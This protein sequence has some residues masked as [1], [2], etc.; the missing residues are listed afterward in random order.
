[1]TI[2]L[3][4]E[5]IKDFH[6]CPHFYEHKH[7]NHEEEPN[8]ARELQAQRFEEILKRVVS[9]F[10]YKR[11]GA[12]TPSYNAL[13]NRW[14]KLWF[15]KNMTAYDLSIERHESAHGNLA[16][17]SN[18]AAAALL[19]FHE[20]FANRAGDPILI[21]E[22]FLIPLSKEVRLQGNFDLILRNKD[23]YQIIKWSSKVRRPGITTFNFDFAALRL[24][25]EYKNRVPANKISYIL[26]DLGST[27]PGAT[28]IYPTQDDLNALL[29]WVDQIKNTQTFIPRRGYTVYC[30][31]CA[32][33]KPCSEFVYPNTRIK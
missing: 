18:A 13:L 21:D 9:F 33:D 15:P 2:T 25:F 5:S 10:F 26:Y 6:V 27:K 31:G 24:A 17:Y 32:Y 8:Y 4:A 7:V 30:K 23:C 16:T 14:E 3:S 19:Q 28:T 20:D 22:E 12:I 11:Q 29:Y 1:M